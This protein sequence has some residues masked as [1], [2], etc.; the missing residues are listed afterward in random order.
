MFGMSFFSL[1]FLWLSLHKVCQY[2][3]NWLIWCASN[4]GCKIFWQMVFSVWHVC[5][6]SVKF[7]KYSLCGKCKHLCDFPAFTDKDATVRCK[8]TNASNK[9]SLWQEGKSSFEVLN[10][11]HVSSLGQLALS[12]SSSSF[13]V[14]HYFPDAFAAS[15]YISINRIVPSCAMKKTWAQWAAFIWE[16]FPI[17]QVFYLYFESCT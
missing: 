14:P 7:N 5:A 4:F 13:C 3:W 11:K 8:G 17:V 1:T 15:N 9:T 12:H 16:S 2:C 6:R 10:M